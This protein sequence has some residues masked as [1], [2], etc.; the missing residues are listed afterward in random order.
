MP[1]LSTLNPQ[2]STEWSVLETIPG[3]IALPGVWRQGF[4]AAFGPMKDLILHESPH[5][6]QL[7]PCPRGCG[8]AHDIICRPDGSLVATCGADPAQP[9]DIPL[10]PAEI[11]PWEVSWSKLGHA[12]FEV[13]E[14]H[15][16]PAPLPLPNTLQIGA[17]SADGVP[18][19]LTVQFCGGTF[20]R[21]VAE[22][23]ARLQVRFILLAPTSFH[24]NAPCQ[25][26]L[27]HARAGF[28]PLETTVLLSENRGLRATRPPG[29]L[30]AQ[31]TPPRNETDESEA[32][33]VFRLFREL[34]AMGTDLAAPPARVFDLMVFKQMT[35]AETARKC[36]CVAS[37]ITQRVALIESHFAMP[38][39]RL[40]AFA[41]DLKE[42]QRTVNGDRY[43][44]KKRGAVQGE[45]AQ[46]ADGDRA[47]ARE[48]EDGYLP[49]ERPGYD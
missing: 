8:L 49:E 31:F 15:G 11:T 12:L 14:L 24:C 33:Q 21:V 1:P 9:R 48:D 19:I 43:A 35:K 38:I 32:A 22:L 27:A 46:F 18:A 16:K 36:K 17:W 30:F 3:L 40:R 13:L 20:R 28:F 23:V 6:A 44:K 41:S 26:L 34:L 2:F 7:L 5:L 25:E 10:T 39:E 37:L 29:E 42:R 47:G 4:G 45:P